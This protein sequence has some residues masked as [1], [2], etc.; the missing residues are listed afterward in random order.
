M[1]TPREMLIA[2]AKAVESSKQESAIGSKK[3][4]ALRNAT[5]AGAQIN[6]LGEIAIKNIDNPEK[7]AESLAGMKRLAEVIVQSM[8]EI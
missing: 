8:A 5:A 2:R 1:K 6:M 4:K 7:I 3:L